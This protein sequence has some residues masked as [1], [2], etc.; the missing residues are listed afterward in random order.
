MKIKRAYIVLASAS[1]LL[2][3]LAAFG[4]LSLGETAFYV[5]VL[6]LIMIVARRSGAVDAGFVNVDGHEGEE[7][8]VMR[9]IAQSGYYL[10]LPPPPEG[11]QAPRQEL[12]C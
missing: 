2:L 5:L 3:L 1:V 4:R 7:D 8:E 6:Y 9:A 10:Q 12:P 11:L